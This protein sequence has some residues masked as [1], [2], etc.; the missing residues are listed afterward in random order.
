MKKEK[1]GIINFIKLMGKLKKIKRSGWIRKVGV[2][3]PESVADHTFR[4]AILCMIIGDMKKLD[5][6]KMLRTALIHD[7]CESIIG[8]LMHYRDE[9]EELQKRQLENNAMI[10]ILS[11]L[12]DDIK[13]NY[14]EI[15]KD[16]QDKESMEA[17]IVREM[18]KLEMVFQALEY[19]EEG[20]DK[21][22]LSEFWKSAENSITDS[23]AKAIFNMLK[24]QSKI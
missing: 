18:D 21:E 7:A 10:K 19:E 12:P 9:R 24:R 16:F 14:S 1:G 2:K 17:K 3:E 11:L 5:T 15:W 6:L 13:K 8:D 22:K 20:Y 23:Y 4:T